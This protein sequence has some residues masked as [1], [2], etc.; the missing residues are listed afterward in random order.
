[1]DKQSNIISLGNLNVTRDFSYISDTVD[2]FIST[3]KAKNI[4]GEIINIGSGYKISIS[5]IV[6]IISK[7]LG[8]KKKIVIEKARLRNKK[9][10][11]TRLCASNRKAKK[12]LNW[13]PQ[14]KS[15]EGLIIGLN[16]TIEWYKKKE[17][18]KKFKSN[19]YNI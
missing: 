15:K 6:N 4:L 1:M 10:E 18:L 16:K 5:E 13:K 14:Y 8:S 12:L 11:V 19:L 9:T 2:G 3:L 17:N 7:I